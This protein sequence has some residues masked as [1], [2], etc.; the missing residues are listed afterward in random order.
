MSTGETNQEQLS[1]LA[2]EIIQQDVCPELRT[3]AAQLVMGN[4]DS[5][6]T[7]VLIGEAPGKKEDETGLPFQGTAGKFLDEMLGEAGLQRADVYV[8]NV[9]KYRPPKNRD[10]KQSEK[11]AFRPYLERELAIINPRV[12]ITLGRHSLWN[13]MP[14]AVIGDVHG[15]LFDIDFHGQ[16]LTLAPLYHPSAGIYNR[17]LQPTMIDDFKKVVQ[18]LQ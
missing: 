1:A 11:D 9:V 14:D 8:T 7:I 17:A 16:S 6:S 5:N 3:Q 13:F 4:G 18:A 10:P 15:Q 12:V 2:A